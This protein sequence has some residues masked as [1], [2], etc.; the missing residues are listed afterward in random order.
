MIQRR[1]SGSRQNQSPSKAER[2]FVKK[3]IYTLNIGGNYNDELTCITYPFIKAWAHKIKADFYE[4]TERKFLDFPARYEKLQIYQLGREH[5]NDWNIF[6]DCDSLVHP[7]MIDPTG[8]LPK[9]TVAHNGKDVASNRWRLDEYFWRDGRH[10]SSCNWLAIASD[11]CLDLWHPL[12][13]MTFDEA[14]KNIFPVVGELQGGTTPEMLID[15]Y[16]LSRNIARYGLK[17]ITIVDLLQQRCGY[18]TNFMMHH[19]Y[20]MPTAEKI[21]HL[22]QCL[23]QWGV[24]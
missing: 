17:F 11:W 1:C 6:L 16:V 21:V 18:Q 9:D 14:C 8:Y 3:T 10:I 24:T 7:D 20:N 12:E 4:I 13:D 19:L 5:G 2:E 23:K 15:D 22:R